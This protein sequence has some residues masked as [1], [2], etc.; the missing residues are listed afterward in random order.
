MR[1]NNFSFG[2]SHSRSLYQWKVLLEYSD[3]RQLENVTFQVCTRK[4]LTVLS[5]EPPQVP[6]QALLQ[7]QTNG[8]SISGATQT[9]F[10]NY[11]FSDQFPAVGLLFCA[12]NNETFWRE[13]CAVS[14]SDSVS[15]RDRKRQRRASTSVPTGRLS[16]SDNSGF[17]MHYI[18]PG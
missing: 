3:A 2:F 9:I 18:Y 4:F 1:E 10:V 14:T 6:T 13:N 7:G 16:L 15:T 12:S 11:T 8:T 5:C 17:P